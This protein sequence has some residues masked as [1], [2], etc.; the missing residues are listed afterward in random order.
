MTDILQELVES[1]DAW[2]AT[3]RTRRSGPEYARFALALQAARDYLVTERREELERLSAIDF[4]GASDE[5]Q[6]ED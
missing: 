6:S 4:S 3:G 5:T 2:F 1:A